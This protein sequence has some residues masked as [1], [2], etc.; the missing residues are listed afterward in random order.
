MDAEGPPIENA[1]L[2]ER[3]TASRAA[4]TERKLRHATRM[5]TWIRL[6]IPRLFAEPHNIGA[7]LL[8]HLASVEEV[9]IV[10]GYVVEANAVVR[11]RTRDGDFKSFTVPG[12]SS[13]NRLGYLATTERIGVPDP[14][15]RI[16]VPLRVV[17]KGTNQEVPVDGD[18]GSL[19]NLFT[20]VFP[21]LEVRIGAG[22]TVYLADDS[23]ANDS[24]SRVITLD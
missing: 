13:L 9:N 3:R 17:F 19:M 18:C 2:E 23:L 15:N 20:G 11:L 12:Y 8:P 24:Q 10:L 7:A 1:R 5:D 21:D 6:V 22:A 16:G 4:T 14:G